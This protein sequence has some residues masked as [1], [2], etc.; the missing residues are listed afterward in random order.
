MKIDCFFWVREMVESPTVLSALALNRVVKVSPVGDG[1]FQIMEMCD[2]YFNGVLP[3]EQLAKLGEELIEMAH[4]QPL[5]Q[6]PG[7]L[8]KLG[9]GIPYGLKLADLIQRVESLRNE[10]NCRIEHGAESDG[11]LD[12]VQT[13]LDQILKDVST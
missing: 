8:P 4:G 9:E 3:P 10:V 6:V 13:Q 2:E 1:T 5:T 7:D 12:Y 11:Q